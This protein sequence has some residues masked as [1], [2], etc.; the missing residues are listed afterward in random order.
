MFPQSNDLHT[1]ESEEY[2]SGSASR[3]SEIQI[4]L[5]CFCT[6]GQR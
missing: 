1:I 6:V 3:T 5:L 4:S 2:A